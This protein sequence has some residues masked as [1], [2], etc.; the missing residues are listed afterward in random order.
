MHLSCRN[1]SGFAQQVGEP[2]ADLTVD[3]RVCD[4]QVE[5]IGPVLRQQQSPPG[6]SAWPADQR[7]YPAARKGSSS[8]RHPSS[9]ARTQMLL[10]CSFQNCSC[11]IARHGF[12]SHCKGF[13]R[14]MS[15]GFVSILP[16]RNAGSPCRACRTSGLLVSPPE[17]A[18]ME[19]ANLLTPFSR[20]D[21][22]EVFCR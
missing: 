6:P 18:I 5:R 14:W 16:Y 9:S 12:C 3:L 22:W 10:C 8:G 13:F 20:A 7:P 15:T 4:R 17:Y 21:Q 19:A 2:G 11:S 1:G